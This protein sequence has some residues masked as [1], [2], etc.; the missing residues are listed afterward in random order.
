MPNKIN[1]ELFSPEWMSEVLST[2]KTG[3]WM[4]SIDMKNNINK[5][6]GEDVMLDLLGLKEALEPEACY[7]HWYDR[8]NESYLD[9][10]WEAVEKII[11]TGKLVEVQYPWN[12]PIFGEIYVRCAGKVES[13]DNGVYTIKGYHQN[14]SDL[15]NLKEDILKKEQRLKEIEEEKNRY[16]DLLQSVLCGIAQYKY[17]DGKIQFKRINREAIKILG[18]S[19]EDFYKKKIWTL[20]DIYV[21]ED[22]NRISKENSNL[23]NAGDKS[24]IFECKIKRPNGTTCWVLRNAQIIL[25]ENG[26]K[27]IQSVFLDI[28]KHIKAEKE[29]R[30]LSDKIAANN[31]LLRVSMEN[32]NICDF[33]YYPDEKLCVMPKRTSEVYGCKDRYDN[34]H[35][36]FAEEYIDKGYYDDYYRMYDDIHKGK[37]T[38]VSIFK[39]K[40]RDLWCRVTLSTVRFDESGKPKLVVGIVEDVTKEKSTEIQNIELN[41][42]SEFM[43]R[44]DYEFLSIVDLD[45]QQYSIKYSALEDAMLKPI[46]YKPQID[47]G[48][49]DDWVYDEDREEYR[50]QMSLYNILDELNSGKEMINVYFRSNQNP[51]R[52]KECRICYFENNK[53]ILITLRDIHDMIQKEENNKIALKEAYESAARAN[54]AKSEFLSRMSHDIRTP[55]NAI[56]GMTSIAK[57]NLNNPVKVLECLDKIT[58]SSD[59]LLNLINE[60]LDMS[61]IESGKLSLTSEKIDLLHLIEDVVTI[62]SPDISKKEQNLSL[63]TSG[64]IHSDV[65][66]DSL[67]LRQV[68]LNILS[69]SMKYTPKGG[70]IELKVNEVN[71]TLEGYGRYE[72]IFKDDGIGMDEE[73]IN[74]I[75]AP[76]E[77]ADDSRINKVHGTGLGMA[78]TKSIVDLM[79]GDIIVESK[80][81]K[82]SKFTVIVN[83]KLQDASE[84]YNKRFI[85]KNILV[86]SD[87][88]NFIN[89]IKNILENVELN[90]ENISSKERLLYIFKEIRNKEKSYFN[91]IID[92]DYKDINSVEDIKNIIEITNHKTP[93]TV[94]YNGKW[95]NKENEA[96]FA[97]VSMFSSKP[98]VKSRVLYQLDYFLK[99][100][101]D[102]DNS[103]RNIKVDLSTK[104]VLLVEDNELNMEVAKELLKITK[105]DVDTAENGKVAYEKIKNTS[106]NHYDLVFMDI[107]M[108]VMNG[109]EA[110]KKIRKLDRDDVKSLPIIAMTANAFLEDIRAAKDAGMNEHIAKPL[111]IE[112]FVNTME[113]YLKDR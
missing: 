74:K 110:T 53:K 29:N 107:Q 13:E 43:I 58:I 103:N 70:N 31:A 64:V 76:F 48:L 81:G 66:S 40:N 112:T 15:R 12:H 33:T 101:V 6:Y 1:N 94:Y 49:R 105:V 90:V 82:G 72:F 38:A 39:A 78:I 34:M 111:S 4:M 7:A 2:S 37:K 51:P 67:R 92:W 97:G 32:T 89:D 10:V 28:D 55:M 59:H 26:E 106:P 16:N 65:I 35:K 52:H 25:D 18:Y 47:K 84:I 98:V 109:Y 95:T 88:S 69:N 108:P 45:K 63:D 27:I 50:R 46:S 20:D 62:I 77:R 5:M 19:E 21:K 79:S 61:K 83:I 3:L 100:D 73:F 85:D 96:K 71:S 44:S 86:I 56:F 22:K 30:E 80:K 11:T 99:N 23:R 68:L 102:K 17:I 93:I 113:K 24:I 60:V 41:A 54:E 91:I 14:I 8:I 42:I 104:R 87:D 75:F 36:D 57:S 9:D